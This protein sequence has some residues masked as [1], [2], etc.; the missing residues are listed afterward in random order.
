MRYRCLSLVLL[1][2]C[3]VLAGGEEPQHAWKNQIEYP[4]EE[5]QSWT[6]PPYVKFTIITKEGFDPNVVYYQDCQ[7]Y[8]YHFDFALEQ[9]DPFIGMTIEEFDDVTLHEAGQQAVLGAV[10]FSPWAD[11]PF[12][13]YGI[14]LVRNDPYRREVIVRLFNIV[15]G[16]IIAEPNVTAYYFPTYEQYT[17]AEQNR[18]WLKGQGISLGSTAQWAEGNAGYSD[19]WALGTLK[20]FTG[21]EIQAAFTNGDLLP[22]DILLTDGV[23]AEIPSVAGI[24]SLMPSTPNSHVAILAKSQGVPFAYL[25]IEQDAI[26]AQNLVNHNVYLAV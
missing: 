19:G 23:P 13:E 25:A 15:K 1:F 26:R 9:L 8:E 2:S 3:L 4:D 14:Q 6:S 11:P 17:V 24:I 20:F 5:F 7:M 21:S 12:N 22:E 16:S 18:D 10:I